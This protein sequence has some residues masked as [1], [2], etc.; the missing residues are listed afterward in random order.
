MSRG[1]S[2]RKILESTIKTREVLFKYIQVNKWASTAQIV[3]HFGTNYHTTANHLD[4]LRRN[5]DIVSSKRAEGAS[6]WVAINDKLTQE[7][8]TMQALED[9]E[10]V[11][12]YIRDHGP[13]N[14]AQIMEALEMADR[15]TS[16]LCK[17]LRTFGHIELV[18]ACWEYVRGLASTKQ[19]PIVEIKPERHF[20]EPGPVVKEIRNGVKYT[21]CGA[22]VAR[23]HVDLKP[24]TGAISRD[25]PG[26]AGLAG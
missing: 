21:Y 15:H 4:Y 10:K 25:F 1:Q 24:G 7:K 5:G 19:A 20:C 9:R 17:W 23:F 8:A 14:R 22:P 16:N 12:A 18:D 3:E 13:C 6:V 2:G 26:L 11:L